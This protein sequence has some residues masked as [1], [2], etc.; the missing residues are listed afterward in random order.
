MERLSD[1][2]ITEMFY[3]TNSIKNIDLS[4]INSTSKFRYASTDWLL[5]KRWLL[6]LHVLILNLNRRFFELLWT[7]VKRF[8]NLLVLFIKIL[9]VVYELTL[10]SLYGHHALLVLWICAHFHEFSSR[11]RGF[12]RNLAHIICEIG[13]RN[14]SVAHIHLFLRCTQSLFNFTKVVVL[15]WYDFSNAWSSIMWKCAV[16][17]CTSVVIIEALLQHTVH[18]HMCKLTAAWIIHRLIC[19]PVFSRMGFS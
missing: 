11:V 12:C 16:K 13:L 9:W 5:W 3:P 1:N 8:G 10:T 17:G 18:A 7:S 6:F 14:Y 4:F 2:T 15:I 19:L